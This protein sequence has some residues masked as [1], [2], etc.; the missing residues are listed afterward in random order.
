VTGASGFVGRHALAPLAER[1]YEVHAVARRRPDGESANWHE[2][3]LLDAGDCRRVVEEAR[4][5]HL[6]HLAWYT[7]HGAYW[8]SPENLPW[9]E[10]SL[11]LVRLFRDRGGERI[12]LAGTCAEYDWTEGLCSEQT[13]PLAP[14]GVYGVCKHALRLVVE[15]YA[16]QAELSAAWGRIFFLFGPWEQPQRLVPSVV[17]AL[18]RGEQAVVDHPEPARDFLYA[19][20]VGAAFAA[21]LD[22]DVRGP[23]NIG[24]GEAMRIG[25]LVQAVAAEVGAPELVHLGG[26]TRVDEAPPLVVADVRRLREEV[27]WQPERSL[28]E[29]VALTVHWWRARERGEPRA[30]LP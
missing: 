17:Q 28:A 22:S 8:N 11:R 10:A 23:V 16:A 14:R 27:G 20:D 5:T 29:A 30:I 2:A 3:D 4:P 24:S 19:G 21:L 18:L 7:A 13:T 1:G 15:A 25:D 26:S 9:V 12:V 6:L